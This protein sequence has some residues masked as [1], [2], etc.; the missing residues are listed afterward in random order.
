MDF[1][2]WNISKAIFCIP[3]DE[4]DEDA[5]TDY[6]STLEQDEQRYNDSKSKFNGVSQFILDFVEKH[7]IVSY[8]EMNDAYRAYTGGSNSFSHILKALRI[9]Y[10]NRPTR[11]FLVKRTDGNYRLA[12]ADQ[13]NWV[14]NDVYND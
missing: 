13:F 5:Y 12:I 7:G 11:R 2:N 14:V 6:R 8:S 9:P 1:I 4:A 10:K 3:D